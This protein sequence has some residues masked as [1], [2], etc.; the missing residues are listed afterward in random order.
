MEAAAVAPGQDAGF[1]ERANRYASKAG[2]EAFVAEM[3]YVMVTL[4]RTGA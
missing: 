3:A 2:D 1:W 4:H